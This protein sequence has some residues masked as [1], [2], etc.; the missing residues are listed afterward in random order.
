MNQVPI[1]GRVHY[2]D[3][4]NNYRV[5]ATRLDQ[6]GTGPWDVNR[7]I[8]LLEQAATLIEAITILLDF[9]SGLPPSTEAAPTEAV[10]GNWTVLAEYA[11]KRAGGTYTAAHP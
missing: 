5:V 4:R 1:V 7:V 10:I 3:V 2:D 11:A 9:L 6:R 8:E